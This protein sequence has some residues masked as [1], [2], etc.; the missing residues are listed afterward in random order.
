MLEKNGTIVIDG[1]DLVRGQGSSPFTGLAHV[2][3]LDLFSVPGIARIQQ[4]T[5]L[6]QST[7]DLPLA[8]V[9]VP[10]GN[11]VGT[12]DGKLY[13]NGAV[14]QSGLGIV[15]DL[16]VSDDY[17]FIFRQ[18]DIDV[19]GPLSS[20]GVTYFSGWKTGLTTGYYHKAQV[21]S[22]ESAIYIANGPYIASITSFVAGVTPATAP[23]AVFDDDA[24][25]FRAGDFAHT[26]EEL[27]DLLVASTHQ[28][29]SYMDI[30]TGIGRL[31]SWNRVDPFYEN[32]LKF[33]EGCP[34]QLL[35]DGSVM[36]SQVGIYGNLYAINAVSSKLLGEINFNIN[37]NASLTPY[38]NAIAKIDDE[39]V[40]G[41]STR[42]ESFDGAT[43]HGIYTLKNGVAYLRN[44]IST[45]NV[46]ASQSM[47]IGAICPISS[48]SVAKGMLIGWQDGSS[49]GVD[50]ITFSPY[51]NYQAYFE[52]QLYK[53]G[54]R[55]NPKQYSELE[56][57]FAKPLIANQGFKVQYRESLSA[58]WT[59]LIT[60]TTANTTAGETTHIF[61]STNGLVGIPKL[62]QIQLRPLSHQAT[63]V[64]FPNN[65][66]FREL[67]LR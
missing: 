11:Y 61:N 43:A 28:G 64:T 45:G 13:K 42:D 4:R 18:S 38:P 39:I 19:Y 16:V 49:A 53:V 6:Y 48:G 9:R 5:S 31:Y 57:T 36:Y 66:E 33:P 29:S 10:S 26:L 63:G 22:M 25:V 3:N 30:N 8:I 14:L 2:R 54:T 50:E 1:N 20:A 47:A 52:S 35:T 34:T 58:T 65:V 46:G 56:V 44:T 17:L 12:R 24:F 62:T 15:Y 41:T 32:L 21:S 59:D 51:P 27:G 7:T 60:I 23:T 40:F 55:G 67:I 37:Q